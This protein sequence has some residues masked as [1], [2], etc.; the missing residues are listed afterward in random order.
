MTK[1]I[2]SSFR[3]CGRHAD[4]A[5]LASAIGQ[6]GFGLGGAVAGVSYASFGFLANAVLAAGAALA[7]AGLAPTRPHRPTNPVQSRQK[8]GTSTEKRLNA[9]YL[10]L[11]QPPDEFEKSKRIVP[12]ASVTPRSVAL[13]TVR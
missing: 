10:A 7:T 5:F 1:I 4:Y 8:A 11:T 13:S 2:S 6:V 12:N 9:E 3:H